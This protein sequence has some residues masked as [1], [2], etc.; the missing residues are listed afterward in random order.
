MGHNILIRHFKTKDES[1]DYA[2]SYNEASLYIKFITK[3]MKKYKLTKINMYTSSTERTLLTSLILYICLYEKSDNN[4]II[5]KPIIDV[6]LYRDPTRERREEISR[7]YKNF[8]SD[9]KTLNIHVT[10][11]STYKSIFIGL[12]ENIISN[13]NE[14]K[15]ITEES[16]IHSNTLS[17]V[18][19][20]SNKH[21]YA[22]NISLSR[23]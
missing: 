15:S 18:N 20:I 8:H 12:L 10:H 2:N 23:K 17:Y 7:Y 22:F 6:K 13:Q 11:S 1:I 16:K 3:Y 21:K 4:F 9:N 19:D 5:N 14:I